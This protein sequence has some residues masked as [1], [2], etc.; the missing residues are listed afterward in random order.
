[1]IESDRNRNYEGV[2]QQ[3]HGG[4]YLRDIASKTACWREVLDPTTDFV[5][6]NR[7][8]VGMLL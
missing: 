1:M 8:I 6:I 4:V 2:Y 5:W 3:K 7:R